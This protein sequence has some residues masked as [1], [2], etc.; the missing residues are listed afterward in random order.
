MAAVSIARPNLM[1]FPNI[2]PQCEGSQGDQGLQVSCT[3]LPN[4]PLIVPRLI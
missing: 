1:K 3:D 4:A 2:D